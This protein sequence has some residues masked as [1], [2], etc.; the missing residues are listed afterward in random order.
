MY[1]VNKVVFG[2]VMFYVFEDG[3]PDNYVAIFK[4]RRE[5]QDFIDF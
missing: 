5:A 3:N 4:T 2:K 1:I